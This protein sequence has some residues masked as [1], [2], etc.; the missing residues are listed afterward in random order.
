M[1]DS[2]VD[3][4]NEQALSSL[5]RQL[6]T[7][8]DAARVDAGLESLARSEAGVALAALLRELEPDSESLAA[9]VNRLRRAHAHPA[10]AAARAPASGRMQARRRVVLAWAGGLAACLALVLGLG[11]HLGMP[12]HGAADT[13]AAVEEGMLLQAGAAIAAHDDIFAAPFDLAPI[14]AGADRE[15]RIFR[16]GFATG[17]GG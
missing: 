6:C 13:A 14:A 17:V 15:D 7:R 12:G 3:A 8:G 4:M 5:Y 16:A 2:T 9:G 11:G 10:R 1:T